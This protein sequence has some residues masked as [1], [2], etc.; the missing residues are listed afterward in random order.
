MVTRAIAPILKPLTG[1]Q[2]AA[3]GRRGALFM[4]L[5]AAGLWAAD[6]A[7]GFGLNVAAGEASNDI[8]TVR[9][10]EEERESILT[11]VLGGKAEFFFAPSHNNPYSG[12][13]GVSGPSSVAL[14]SMMDGL[15]LRS[16]GPKYTCEHSSENS[17]RAR[18]FPW[19]SSGKCL[20]PPDTRS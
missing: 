16:A 8:K 13:Q 20:C 6:K 11:R 7:L 3:F 12:I 4:S 10:D 18:R 1:V 9:A 2:V 19:R 15:G 5:G 14:Q 17:G